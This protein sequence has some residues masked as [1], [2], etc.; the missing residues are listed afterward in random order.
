MPSREY[1]AALEQFPKGIAVP[2]DTHEDVRRKF[3]PA[4]GHD[5]GRT[6]RSKTRALGACAA[7]GRR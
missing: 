6:S 2:G 1:L 5:P 3:A 7:P 4:H